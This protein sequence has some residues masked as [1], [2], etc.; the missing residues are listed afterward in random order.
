MAETYP[1]FISFE[2][3]DFSGKST[4]LQHLREKLAREGLNAE[5]LREPGG[6][7][8]SEK[9]RHLL[10]SP[11]NSEMTSR[12]EILLYSAAR[13]QLVE[14]VIIPLLEKGHYLIADRFFD[15]TTAYQGYGRGLD[16]AFVQE[17]NRFAT[18]GLKP[19]RTILIDVSPET[20]LQRRKAAGRSDDRLDSESHAFY[21]KIYHGYHQIVAAEPERFIVVDGENPIEA[22]ANAVYKAVS[23]IWL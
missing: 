19:Y 6:N 20:A 14:Q 5:L 11:E 10:L 7:V 18:S 3:I 12:A 15:S 1:R 23:A 9:I 8:I 17:L 13:A 22:V 21:Q 16:E 4:Q 2:G